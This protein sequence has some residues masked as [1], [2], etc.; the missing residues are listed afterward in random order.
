MKSDQ[1]FVKCAS[2]RF[3]SLLVGGS[4]CSDHVTILGGGWGAGINGVTGLID[5]DTITL[6]IFVVCL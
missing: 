3:F 6:K 2:G 4:P 1:I 5:P